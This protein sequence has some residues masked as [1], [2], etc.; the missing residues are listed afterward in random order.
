MRIL[1]LKQGSPEWIE[2]RKSHIGGSD[3]SAITGNSPWKDALYLWEEKVGKRTNTFKSKAM[4]HGTF[5]EEKAREFYIFVSGND[6]TPEVCESDDWNIAISSLD[7]LSK[8]RRSFLEVKCPTNPK[9]YDMALNEEIPPYY[10]DQIQWSFL[11]TG[12]KYC[13]YEVYIDYRT[14][15][16]IRVLPDK[17]YQENILK[18]A[19]EFWEYVLS[20]KAPPVKNPLNVVDDDFDNTLAEELKKWDSVEKEAKQKVDE[21]KILLKEK[22]FNEK[23][24][25]FVEAGVKMCWKEGASL[26]DWKTYKKDK[27]IKDEDL[28]DYTKK[29]EKSCAFTFV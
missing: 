20:N 13:D 17:D 3:V 9:L 2:Y 18:L 21:I 11:V 26:V 19:K 15:K 4:E 24:Y 14:N 7:G 23:R 27:N 12:C 6:V 1:K 22:Y 5:T 29:S 25:S 8:D 10:M 28:K 16:I